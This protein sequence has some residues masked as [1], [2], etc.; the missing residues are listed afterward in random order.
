MFVE[1]AIAVGAPGEPERV[2]GVVVLHLV[3][4]PDD[5]ERVRA[6][7]GLEV[8]VG[9]VQ[10]VLEPVALERLGLGDELGRQ[11]RVPR[12]GV[13]GDPVL[14]RVVAEMD[15]EVVVLASD[16]AVGGIEAVVPLLAGD[17][18][19]REV[20]DATRGAVRVQPTGLAAEPVLKR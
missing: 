6:V 14:V 3:V 7:G 12:A 1:R 8:R 5:D 11:V 16:L 13:V 2:A 20:A 10:R 19:E 15:D 9:L 4:V 17:E 18:A